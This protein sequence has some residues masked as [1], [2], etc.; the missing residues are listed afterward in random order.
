MKR[1]E[2]EFTLD[3]GGIDKASEAIQSWLEEAGAEHADI[4]RIRLL[5]EDLLDDIRN[6]YE[7]AVRLK[8]ILQKLT[9]TFYLSMRYSGE[10]FDPT[11]DTDDGL[12]KMTQLLMTQTGLKPVWRRRNNE[13]ELI[14]RIAGRHMR[15]EQLMVGCILL[16]LAVGF[17]GPLI[18]LQVRTVIID[19]GLSFLS[20][21]FLNLL[22]TFIG[23]M[24]FLS[25][26]NG[27]CGIGSASVLGKIGKM[28]ITRFMGL[29]FLLTA[30]FTAAAY[31]FFPLQYGGGAD[32]EQIHTIFEVIFG[33]IPSNPVS[34]FLE[35]NTLQI[36]FIAAMVGIILVL[37]GSQ[38]EHL[39]TLIF[40]LQ[41]VIMRCV[42]AVCI[43]L[44]VY[45]FSSLV[46]QMWISGSE[47]FMQ[48]G[49]PLLLCVVLN[50]ISMGGLLACACMKLKV[51]ASVLIKKLTPDF[52][53]GFATAS[54]AAALPVSLE[55]NEKDL[56][57]DPAFSKVAAP[58][59][60]ILLSA[61]CALPFV[62]TAA[63]LADHFGMQVNTA[64]WITLWI[65]AG[66]LSMAVPPVAGGIISCLAIL[67]SQMGIPQTGIALAVTLATL[68]DF[69]DT[70]ARI[71]ILHLE[72]ALQADKLK[73]LDHAVLAKPKEQSQG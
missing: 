62:L 5:A 19:Y 1:K 10:R 46:T 51:K 2:M 15:P 48:F 31:L 57:I 65:V 37:A 7:Q 70:A 43:L 39:R 25:V 16:A 23:L 24:V 8:V 20:K 4:L 32:S 6:H 21:G 55:I 17:A 56:G 73:R 53:I 22:N 64:W 9:G 18:P 63:F 50:F 52:L 28:M 40:E 69:P 61:T 67:L 3:A 42:S 72:T 44:P 34:P 38:T 26:V 35:G 41:S 71:F 49:K 29:T 54:G 27:I 59:G 47:L 60:T 45:I 36:V 13:N 66:L 30:F 33:I 12:P 58:I 11:E 14:L 68:M